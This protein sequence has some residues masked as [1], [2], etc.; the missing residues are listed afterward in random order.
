MSARPSNDDL[1]ERESLIE[2]L[3]DVLRHS[4]LYD[5]MVL[6]AGMFERICD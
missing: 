6:D 2:P 1:F 4:V 5:R 3:L